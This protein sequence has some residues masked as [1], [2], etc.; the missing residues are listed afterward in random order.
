MKEMHCHIFSVIFQRNQGLKKMEIYLLMELYDM[1]KAHKCLFEVHKM[2]NKVD[3]LVDGYLFITKEDA[4]LAKEE[5]KKI[6]YLEKR[7]NYDNPRSVLSV[8]EKMTETKMFVTPLGLAYLNQIRCFL[9]EHLEGELL[10]PYITV[11]SIYK[12]EIRHNSSVVQAKISNHKKKKMGINE[13]S[14]KTSLFLNVLLIFLVIAMFVITVQGE[15]ANILNYKT[16][17]T[18]QYATWEQEL[19]QREEAVKEKER[20][21][22]IPTE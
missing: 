2:D 14:I 3:Y 8:Y 5:K 17:L 6:E 1:I 21:L 12:R 22:N 18:N 19:T 20:E 16:V 4:D 13:I 11:P 15:N 7:M 10:V 9:Q